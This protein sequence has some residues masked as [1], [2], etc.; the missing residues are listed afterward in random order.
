MVTKKTR[1]LIV[2][3]VLCGTS[4][5]LAHSVM[6]QCYLGQHDDVICP[7]NGAPVAGGTDGGEGPIV[8]II[9]PSPHIGVY[10]PEFPIYIE[11]PIKPNPYQPPPPCVPVK[12]TPP[13][14]DTKIPPGPPPPPPTG[15]CQDFM[16]AMRKSESSGG[17]VSGVNYT[18][19]NSI[20]CIGAYQFC[21]STLR[22]YYSGSSSSFLNDP[23]AQDQA[24]M[25]LVQA[26]WSYL[27]SKGACQA[28]GK[29]ID[30]A[31]ITPAALVGAAHLGGAGGVAK[32]L[33]TNGG[34]N[35]SDGHTRL[36]DY[37]NKFGGFDLSSC[38][39]SCP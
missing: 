13:P 24:F 18:C 22:Q 33:N 16:A 34:Y 2:F 32:F 27:K 4:L 11:I 15:S 6:A 3:A 37:A 1:F 26:N 28:M 5:S 23:A 17:C 38:G 10:I 39:I 36:S 21:P 31:T 9:D 12:P 30:G 29:T 8:T 14:P 25:K 35:P 7:R 19:V 20:N